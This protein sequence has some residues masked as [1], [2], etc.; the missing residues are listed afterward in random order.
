MILKVKKLA[1]DAVLPQYA[2]P[3]DAGRGLFSNAEKG[4]A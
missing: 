3:G 2:H 4:S 1:A